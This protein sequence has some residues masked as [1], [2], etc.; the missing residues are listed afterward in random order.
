MMTPRSRSALLAIAALTAVLTATSVVHAQTTTAQSAAPLQSQAPTQVIGGL[1]RFAGQL[2][3]VQNGYVFLTT[4]DAFKL[5]PVVRIVDAETGQPTT[6]TPQTRMYVRLDF[7]TTSGVVTEMALAKKRIAGE[8][9]FEEVKQFAIAQSK[10]VVNPELIGRKGLTGK[11]VLV[12]F[13]VE[14]PASTPYSDQVYVAT[15]YSNWDPR[16]I[17]MDRFDALHYRVIR[18]LA[19]GTK[20]AYR[21]T[22]G[23]WNSVERGRDGLE[24]APHQ[25]DV[26]EVDS[27]AERAIVTRW[28]DENPLDPGQRNIGP[29]NIPTPFQVNPFPSLPA[30]STPKPPKPH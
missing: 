16:A 7:D 30:G 15:D 14:V 28:S 8:K 21:V 3:D 19:S 18:K 17:H 2:L 4:G 6:V 22:R 12:V 25:V 9:S 26:K 24:P 20:F 11:P 1:L 23:S 27:Q 29:G 5:A 13:T 10:P